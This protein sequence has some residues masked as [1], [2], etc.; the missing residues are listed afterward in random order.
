MSDTPSLSAR[1]PA[2]YDPESPYEGVDL[3]EYPEWWQK[4]IREFEDH[5]LRPY[6]PSQFTDGEIVQSLRDDL[7]TE[8]DVS[9]ALRTTGPD[10]GGKWH[11]CVDGDPI[12]PVSRRRTESGFTQYEI[13]S[14]AFERCV[15]DA[16]SSRD[17]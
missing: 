6:R 13:D 3:T 12:R 15:R 11:I 10:P 1:L 14:D 5:G 8:L 16:A 17:R 4:N 9:I 7:A 2:G